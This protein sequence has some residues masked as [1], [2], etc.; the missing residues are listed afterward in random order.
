MI[1]WNDCQEGAVLY[2]VF[3]PEHERELCVW[4]VRASARGHVLAERRGALT[5]TP[6]FGPDMGDVAA[7]EVVTEKLIHELADCNLPATQGDYQPQAVR[8]PPSEPM[9]HAL[10]FRLIEDYVDAQRELGVS[11][12]QTAQYLALPVDDV[13]GL[14]P[15]A[16]TVERDRRMRR[17][18]ALRDAMQRHPA[19]NDQREALVA[20]VL[21]EDMPALTSLLAAFLP[22]L[23][24]EDERTDLPP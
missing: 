12:H 20:A 8:L 1:K 3:L 13:A 21:A 17:L 9:T 2:E 7:I 5:W 15:Y 10:L 16:V 19:M 24:I 14:H 4:L 18:I 23:H 11:G 6:R 22:G